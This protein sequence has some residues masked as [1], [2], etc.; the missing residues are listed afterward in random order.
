MKHF[1]ST[2]FL[3]ICVTA[4]TAQNTD[5]KVLAD[6]LKGTYD[7][8]CKSGKANGTGKAVGIHTYD[9]EFKNG[10]PEGKGKYTWPNGDYY[11]GS[12]KKGQKE[13]KGELHSFAGGKESKVTGYWKKDHYRGEYEEPYVITNK[14][15]EIGR[16][17]VTKMSSKERTFTVTVESL[18]NNASLS[19]SSFQTATVM[20]S[21]QVTRGSYVS[22]SSNALTN[23]EITTFRGIIFPF[24]CI[25]NFGTSMVE[26]EI[27]E[28]GGWD[29]VVPINK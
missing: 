5:C 8:E 25:L 18:Q 11:Y 19:S 3:I 12:W 2:L 24:R 9:G 29:M 20:T 28:E 26:I 15:N 23:K 6:S 27:F 22:K 10:L 4:A 13:G 1:F 17:Q 16:V 21:H 14:T 7:G